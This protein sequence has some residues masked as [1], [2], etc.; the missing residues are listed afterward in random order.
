MFLPGN[1]CTLTPTK[2]I[3]LHRRASAFAK[4]GSVSRCPYLRRTLLRLASDFAGAVEVRKGKHVLE[5]KPTGVDKGTVIATFL[6]DAPFRGR[7]LVFIGDDLT[8]ED[9]FALVNCRAGVSI[10]VGRGASC[11]QYRLRDAAAVRNWL[12]RAS[13]ARS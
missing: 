4:N 6:A 7:R 10:K 5:V 1:K 12:G 8:D 3:V 2:S 13:E 11:A 9:G